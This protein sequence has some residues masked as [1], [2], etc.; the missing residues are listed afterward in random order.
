MYPQVLLACAP[1]GTDELEYFP[2]GAVRGPM[3]DIMGKPYDI[4]AFTQHLNAS[5]D[6]SRGPVFQRTGTAR[7][8]RFRFVN[9]LLQ[10]YVLMKG[11]SS[12]MISEERI[13]V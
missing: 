12:K 4:P 2:A 6:E 11:V 9:P 1:A 8:Y 5:C 13:E 7:R 10:P 3:I